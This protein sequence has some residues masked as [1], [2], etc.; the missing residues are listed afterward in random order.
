MSAVYPKCHRTSLILL[1]SSKWLAD[2]VAR[3][4]VIFERV[5]PMRHLAFRASVFLTFLAGPAVSTAEACSCMLNPPCAAA[6]KADAVFIATAVETFEER[7]IPR[8]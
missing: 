5:M 1:A 2:F 3:T 8:S 6:W 7:E 4:G